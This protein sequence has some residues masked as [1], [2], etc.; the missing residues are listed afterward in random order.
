MSAP[1][2]IGA[3]HA[4]Q[5][6]SLMQ[7]ARADWHVPV[8]QAALRGE[9]QT[10]ILAAGARMP[11]A[12]LDPVRN[13]KPLIVILGDD[14]G[15]S[16]GPDAFPQARR[17]FRWAR[18]MMLHGAGGEPWHY[19]M[20][21]EAAVLMGRVLIVETSSAG[22]PAWVAFK[23]DHAPKVQGVSFRVPEGQPA[24]PAAEVMQ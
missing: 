6:I 3:G 2:H 21:A 8:V 9:S 1:I 20:A 24:H 18:W 13:P 16:E 14:Y 10:M 4:V 11:L 22:L 5:M 17:L 15:P 7:A 12:M 19:A 23:A